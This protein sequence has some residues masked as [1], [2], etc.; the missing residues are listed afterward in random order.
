M[1]LVLVVL[2]LLLGWLLLEVSKPSRGG[3]LLRSLRRRL[4]LRWRLLLIEVGKMSWRLGILL[5]Y[6]LGLLLLLLV[7][8]GKP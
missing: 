3:L 6:R 2:H 4:L 8:V 7:E 5:L 1:L